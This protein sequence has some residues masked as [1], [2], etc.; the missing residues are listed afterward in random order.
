MAIKDN[1]KFHFH[2]VSAREMVNLIKAAQAGY[3]GPVATARGWELVSN[4]RS[5]PEAPT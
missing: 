2:Y 1:P 5:K 4:V 3:Q